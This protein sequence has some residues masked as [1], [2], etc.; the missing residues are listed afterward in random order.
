MFQMDGAVVAV[1][2][3]SALA[4][5]VGSLYAPTVGVALLWTAALVPWAGI[6]VWR[7]PSPLWMAALTA[8]LLA[9]LATGLLQA[10]F[11]ETYLANHPTE[12]ATLR[13]TSAGAVAAQ[14]VGIAL[15]AGTVWGALAGGI[16]W[17]VRRF[18]AP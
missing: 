8:G 6:L 4:V 5:A 13:G 2:V 14:F 18:V 11:Q 12:A 3:L 15:I 1:F 9:G 10:G 7:A 16:A 17:L